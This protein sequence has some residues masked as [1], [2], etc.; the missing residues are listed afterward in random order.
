MSTSS[1]ESDDDD[2][3]EQRMYV[4]STAVGRPYSR[5]QGS[6]LSNL[7]KLL[8]EG[9]TTGADRV[10]RWHPKI[11]NALEFNCGFFYSLFEVVHTVVV[12]Y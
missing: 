9:A 12:Q 1:S 10:L 2:P 4:S 7:Q 3:S 5:Y 11:S 8:N 6:Y